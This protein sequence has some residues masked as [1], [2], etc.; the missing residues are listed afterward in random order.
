MKLS[1]MNR[2][3]NSLNRVE[4]CSSMDRPEAALREQDQGLCHEENLIA[5]GME[6]DGRG[7]VRLTSVTSEKSLF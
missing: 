5:C 6:A 3:G 1:L 2:Y 4:R 7:H